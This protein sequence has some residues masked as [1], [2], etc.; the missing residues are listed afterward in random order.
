MKKAM[1]AAMLGGTLLAG[2][3]TAAQDRPMRPDPLAQADANGDGVVTRDEMLVDVDARFAQVDTDKDSRI[4]PA[5]REAAAERMGAGSRSGRMGGRMM[6]RL[7]ADDD[8]FISLEEQ[9][10]QATRRFDRLDANADGKVDQAERE[11]A[12]NR[13]GGRRGPGGPGGD[14]PPPPANAPD[15]PDGN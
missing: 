3:A 9:R 15:T 10:A 11:A 1:I 13:M 12:R 6:D 7:D 5:E 14:M 4:S 2:S 8:G